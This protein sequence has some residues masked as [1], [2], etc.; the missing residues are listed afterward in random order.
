M[1]VL[2]FMVTEPAP[3]Y[4]EVHKLLAPK[5]RILVENNLQP[6]LGLVSGATESEEVKLESDGLISGK[7]L[8]P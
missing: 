3:R 5:K 8:V 1:S 7:G 2:E 6:G 4:S